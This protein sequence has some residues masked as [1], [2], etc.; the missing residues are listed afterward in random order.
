MSMAFPFGPCCP[1]YLLREKGQGKKEALRSPQKDA[2]SITNALPINQKLISKQEAFYQNF[3]KTENPIRFGQ[4]FQKKG[5]DILSHN[6]AV[7]SAQAGLT[8]LF[9]MGRGEPRRN[10]H[11]K[12]IRCKQLLTINYQS[13]NILTYWDKET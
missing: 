10:N 2:A 5:D 11:L 8:S 4:G 1:L 7:P 9:G 12:A 3:Q 6:N 13:D